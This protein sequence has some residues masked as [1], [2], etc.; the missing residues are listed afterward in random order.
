MKIPVCIIA[1]AVVAVELSLKVSYFDLLQTTT[2]LQGFRADFRAS[3]YTIS[4][5]LSPIP[6]PIRRY[7]FTAQG[8]EFGETFDGLSSLDIDLQN[9]EFD[10]ATH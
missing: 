4:I 5:Q 2:D 3:K 7:L 10:L 6:M 9:V 1:S 8:L